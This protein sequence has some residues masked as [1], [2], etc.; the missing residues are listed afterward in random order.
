MTRHNGKYI[1]YL[2]VSTAK[3]GNPALASRR[4][5]PRSRP[6]STAA[7]WELARGGRRDRVR[8]EP[9]QPPRP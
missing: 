7:G 3:Q 9:S 1:S 6:G 8:Q 5:A 2:R 4:N